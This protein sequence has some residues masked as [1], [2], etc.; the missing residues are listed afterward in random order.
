MDGLVA[1][2]ADDAIA[3]SDGGGK[4][5]AARRPVVG[6]EHVARFVAGVV[7]KWL[8]AGEVR[9]DPVNGGLGLSLHANGRLRGVLTIDSSGGRVAQVFIVVN[10]DKLG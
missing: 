3:W 1:L 9:I 10:P 2:L 6:A 7:H 8:S 5:A 4:F